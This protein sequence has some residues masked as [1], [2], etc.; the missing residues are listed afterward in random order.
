MPSKRVIPAE[1]EI[2]WTLS[3]PH[4]RKLP[5]QKGSAGPRPDATTI[6]VMSPGGSNRIAER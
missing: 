6:S 1:T 4:S 2:Q 3:E 5:I